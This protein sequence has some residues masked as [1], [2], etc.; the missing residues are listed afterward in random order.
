MCI[1][2]DHNFPIQCK[3]Y[4]R[5]EPCLVNLETDT[6]LELDQGDLFGILP[7]IHK[8][9]RLP[10]IAELVKVQKRDSLSGWLAA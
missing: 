2:T 4:Y 1:A 3:V 6:Y 10:F 9:A 8:D 5:N 7:V